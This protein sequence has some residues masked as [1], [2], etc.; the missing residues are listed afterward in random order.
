MRDLLKRLELKLA[1]L[2]IRER[3][4]RN[5]DLKHLKNAHSLQQI[6]EQI[7]SLQIQINMNHI[8]WTIEQEIYKKGDLAHATDQN[9]IVR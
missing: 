2:L 8:L 5:T 1:D 3:L 9:E 7:K 4:L 6:R